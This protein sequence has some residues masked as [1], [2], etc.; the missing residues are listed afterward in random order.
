MN[1]RELTSSEKL[2]RHLRHINGHTDYQMIEI[3]QINPKFNRIESVQVLKYAVKWDNADHDNPVVSELT[4]KRITAGTLVFVDNPYPNRKPIGTGRVQY[5]INDN[6]DNFDTALSGEP[7]GKNLEFLASHYGEK[8][9]KIIDPA[10]EKV[11][12][13]RHE[14]IVEALKIPKAKHKFDPRYN[15][16][17]MV[18]DRV[19]IEVEQPQS[20]QELIEEFKKRDAERDAMMLEMKKRL[21]EKETHP[22]PRKPKRKPAEKKKA[23]IESNFATE[24]A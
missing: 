11:V 7:K 16:K 10:W 17:G 4:G 22:A 13:K 19:K 14:A 15:L 8:L 3:E 5:L 1:K 12:K 21:D 6:E 23:A 18:D 2:A 24:E 9:F 20:V